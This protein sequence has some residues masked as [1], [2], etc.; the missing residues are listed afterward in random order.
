M[1]GGQKAQRPAFLKRLKKSHLNTDIKCDLELSGG[2]EA[3]E[4]HLTMEEK[5]YLITVYSS[6][7]GSLTKESKKFFKILLS[8]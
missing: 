2:V 4:I 3:D 6:N 5:F 8:F 7:E 1:I